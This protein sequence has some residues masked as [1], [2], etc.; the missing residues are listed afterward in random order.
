[1]AVSLFGIGTAVNA[2]TSALSPAWPTGHAIDDIGLLF[3][4][5]SGAG[6]TE[7]LTSG[8]GFTLINTYSTGTGTNGT[9]LS[10]YWARATSAAMASPVVQAG[11][12]FK[13]GFI[14]AFRGVTSFG[15]PITATAGGT[16]AAASTTA[17]IND[18]TTT[19][20]N[21]MVINAI[22]TDLDNDTAFVTSFTNANLSALTK[23]FDAG[24]ITGSGGEIAFSTGLKATPG[25]TGTTDVVMT[26]GIT[27]VISI[28]LAPEPPYTGYVNTFEGGTDGVTLTAANTGGVSGRQIVNIA[29]NSTSTV[30]F[31]ST[32]ARNTLSMRNSY[33]VAGAGYAQWTWTSAVRTVMRYYFYVETEIDAGTVELS[34]FRTTSNSPGLVSLVAQSVKFSNVSGTGGTMPTKV[35]ANTWY[36]I[37]VAATKGTTT[38][39][40][41]LEGA[42]YQGDSLTPL[43][44]YDSGAVV[45]M[46]TVNFTVVR[47]G[48]PNGPTN[49]P[50]VIYYDDLSVQELASGWIGPSAAPYD[51]TQFMP[52]FWH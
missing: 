37:E 16:N 29:T 8:N 48:I 23:Q 4:T 7:T 14:A 21:S 38:S 44:T 46:D 34:R 25:A 2:G 20:A 9:R 11:T 39:N 42:V 24:T 5:S 13:F 28:A 43:Y 6:R 31:S 52:F 10:V 1:M 30:T 41:R 49:I 40:G 18:I 45:N 15:N 27:A 22:A 19:V 33:P 17:S 35:V 3:V 51:T 26:S 32:V 12:D 36:R 47:L 50:Q